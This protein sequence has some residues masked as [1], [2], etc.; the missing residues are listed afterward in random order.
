MCI[1]EVLDDLFVHCFVTNL[2]NGLRSFLRK[3]LGLFYV[4]IHIPYVLVHKSICMQV[5][6]LLGRQKTSKI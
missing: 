3:M 6:P 5:D 4:K 1:W 2:V